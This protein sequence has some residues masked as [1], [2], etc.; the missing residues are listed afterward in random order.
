M[1]GYRIQESA[2]KDYIDHLR[3]NER[4][5]ATLQKY[6]RDLQRFATW[7]ASQDGN[8]LTKAAVVAYKA[9]LCTQYAPTS[10]NSILAA[11]NGFLTHVGL[12]VFRVKPLRIQRV[13]YADDGRE[14]TRTEYLR[15]VSAAR[16]RGDERLALLLQTL[17]SLGLRVSE[18]C[19]VTVQAVHRERAEVCNKGKCRLVFLPRAL[20]TR[21]QAYCRARHIQSGP[22]FV[23]RSGRPLD[24]S[25]I[26]S[27]MKALCQAAKVAPRK[28]FPHN[29]R[30]LFAQC[31]YRKLKDLEHL[32]SILGHSSL[33][34]TRI[35]TRT[36]GAEYRRQMEQLALLL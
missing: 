20:C 17:C 29:L 2:I 35:Y 27:M 5:P 23:T 13:L 36:T 21:L 11:V 30:H 28:V 15:L 4:S 31:F 7:M 32:A 16:V 24:R 10:V 3:S 14:L 25:N 6:Q 18:L 1:S 19:S 33:N 22:V 8:R 12:A 9:E 34:T 26:W